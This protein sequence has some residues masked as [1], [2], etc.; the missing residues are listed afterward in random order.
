MSEGRTGPQPRSG[1]DLFMVPMADRLNDQFR[2]LDTLILSM[3]DSWTYL[4]PRARHILWLKL[5]SAEQSFLEQCGMPLENGILIHWSMWPDDLGDYAQAVAIR[6]SRQQLEYLEPKNVAMASAMRQAEVAENT[7]RLQIQLAQ[8]LLQ[9]ANAGADVKDLSRLFSKNKFDHDSINTVLSNAQEE[10]RARMEQQRSSPPGP[11]P[12]TPP[13]NPDD[14]PE[15]SG[16]CNE[17][18]ENREFVIGED[19]QGKYLIEM[20][21]ECYL[22]ITETQDPSFDEFE[23]LMQNH[24]PTLSEQDIMQLA[25]IEWNEEDAIEQIFDEVVDADI[26]EALGDSEE[27]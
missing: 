10:M 20:C 12:Q 14:E 1:R 13:P 15:L 6:M 3:T 5:A 11:P 9:L 8:S 7:A 24:D 27:E 22:R 18:G 16:I 26:D 21:E 25:E 4:P 2:L 17:C 23:E 19:E